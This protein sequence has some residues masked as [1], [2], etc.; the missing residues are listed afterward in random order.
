MKQK[1][2]MNPAEDTCLNRY[3]KLVTYSEGKPIAVDSP[4]KSDQEVQDFLSRI[5]T[6]QGKEINRSNPVEVGTLPGGCRIV[7]LV[8]PVV[9]N[10]AF[11]IRK[12]KKEE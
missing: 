3:D 10:P 6:A 4:F 11:V 2:L 9:E 5:Y 7:A 12:L 1:E 8:P